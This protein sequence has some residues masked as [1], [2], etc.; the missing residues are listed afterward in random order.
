VVGNVRRTDVSYRITVVNHTPRLAKIAV[1]DQLPVSRHESVV[2][3]D[4]TTSPAPDERTDLGVL[5]WTVQLP[6]GAR[7]EI[8]FSFRLEHPRGANLVGWSD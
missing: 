2:I 8:T 5:T 3:R 1:Q 6:P 7:K 4:V